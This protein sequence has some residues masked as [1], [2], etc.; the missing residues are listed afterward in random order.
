MRPNKI[1][2]WSFWFTRAMR[3][4]LNI[5]MSSSWSRQRFVIKK[6]A[7]QDSDKFFIEETQNLFCFKKNVICLRLVFYWS[8]S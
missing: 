2:D 5:R 8:K 1:V 4:I 7:F 3:L 6:I